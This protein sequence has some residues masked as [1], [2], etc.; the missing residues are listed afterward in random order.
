MKLHWSKNRLWAGAAIVFSLL[1]AAF[2]VLA[3]P[4]GHELMHVSVILASVVLAFALLTKFELKSKWTVPLLLLTVAFGGVFLLHIGINGRPLKVGAFVYNMHLSLA[5]L[6]LIQAIAGNLK[7]SSGIWLAIC[8][9]FGLVD[10]AVYQFRG[11]QIVINDVLSIGTAVSV[12]GNYKLSIDAQIMTLI[13]MFVAVMIILCRAAMPKWQAQKKWWA[14]VLC[15]VLAALLSWL[16]VAH[17][18]RYKTYTWANRGAQGPG[19]LY[20]FALELYNLNV[21]PP[22][23]YSAEAVQAI[24]EEYQAAAE[25]QNGRKPHVIAVMVES[26]S[27]LTVLGDIQT[28]CEIMPWLDEFMENTI[29]GQAVSSVY[30][31]STASSEWEFLTGNSMAFMPSGTLVYRQYVRDDIRTIADIMENNGYSTL[32]LHPY[33]ANG[34]DRSRIYEMIGFDKTIFLEDAEWGETVRDYVS[35]D[36]FVDMLI[37]EFENRDPEKPMFAFGITMQN[38]GGYVYEGYEATVDVTTPDCDMSRAEQYLSLIRL[39]DEALQKLIT[40]FENCGEDVI[41]LAFG[42]HQPNILTDEVSDAL[43]NPTMLQQH[44]VPYFV[45]KNYEADA[46]EMPLTSINYLSTLLMDEAGIELPAY[47]QFLQEAQQ[48]VPVITEAGV[49]ID[50]EY[51]QPEDAPADMQETL[52]KYHMLEYAQ[53][54]DFTVDDAVFTGAK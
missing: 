38:H 24:A 32:A 23:G 17:L 48:T 12:M 28:D 51:V 6:L 10:A 13:I 35:D 1:L 22:E 5:L 18:D 53:V 34:W 33:F 21:A 41:V 19:I 42:D 4:A 50:G 49:V 9:V 52:R 3:L 11:S 20:E 39:T 26:W 30:G 31:G 29:H 40:Y 27:D 25:E 2:S 15:V 47:F 46:R 54:F 43:D 7:I 14:R 37:Q 8:G 36:A 45:W 44:I 16:P